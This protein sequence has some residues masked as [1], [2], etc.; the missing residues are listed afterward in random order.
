MQ[1]IMFRV[2]HSGFTLTIGHDVEKKIDDP[3]KYIEEWRQHTHHGRQIRTVLIGLIQTPA[4]HR[5]QSR[6]ARLQRNFL[7]GFLS[8]RYKTCFSDNLEIIIVLDERM[9]EEKEHII[10][11]LYNMIPLT[12][13]TVNVEYRLWLNHLKT[14]D[15]TYLKTFRKRLEAKRVLTHGSVEHKLETIFQ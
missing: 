10:I 14:G 6:A 9:T 15:T 2:G 13:G 5:R 7:S 8:E 12:L 11:A 3:F 1:H 4:V